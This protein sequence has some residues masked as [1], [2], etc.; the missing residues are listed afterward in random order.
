MSN[1]TCFVIMAI[2]EQVHDGGTITVEELRQKYNDLIK[3][4]L[5]KARPNLEVVRADEVALPGTITTDIVTRLMHSTFVVADITYPN[6][7]VFYELGLRHACRTGTFIIRDK[8]GPAAPFDVAH[9]RHI[10][11]DNSATGLR[12]LSDKFKY[13]FGHYDKNPQRPDNQ[14]LELAK[15]TGYQFLNYAPSDTET[16][17]EKA[18]MAVLESPELV[19]LFSRQQQ[20]EPIDQAEMM[21]AMQSNPK[22]AKLFLSAMA[23]SGSLSFRNN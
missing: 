21:K 1:E 5:L 13:W 16:I 3:E 6:P 4:A 11:Y 14:F 9:L 2:G 19:D 12:T 22:V 18:F 23:K 15:L 7:N 8:Q 20:G 10:E 17:E